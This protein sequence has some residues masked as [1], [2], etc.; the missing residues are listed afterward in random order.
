L[1]EKYRTANITA[2]RILDFFKI[3]GELKVVD[4]ETLKTVK[5]PVLEKVAT[6][7][8]ID[9]FLTDKLLKLTE[10]HGL[11]LS[12][13]SI[14]LLKNS[15]FNI[16]H[17]SKAPKDSYSPHRKALSAFLLPYM[18]DKNYHAVFYRNLDD[19]QLRPD[20]CLVFRI[21]RVTKLNL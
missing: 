14:E 17:I 18:F 2:G 21:Q 4:F 3:I 12:V 15:K 6:K 10:N 16:K 9:R 13:K 19:H 5:K 7:K 20:A 1:L 11:Q 8:L